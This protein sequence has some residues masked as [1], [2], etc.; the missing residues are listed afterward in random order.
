MNEAIEQHVEQFVQ[1][2]LSIA[3]RARG[4]S[5]E[6]ALQ[7]VT[8]MLSGMAPPK[9]R[10]P[11]VAAAPAP[12]PRARRQP[13]PLKATREVVATPAKTTTTAKT[14][15]GPR[16]ASRVAPSAAPVA[17]V[18]EATTSSAA[19]ASEATGPVSTQSGA[20]GPAPEREVRVLD[21]VT[22]LGRA[23]AAEIAERCGQPNGSV[24]VALRG[25]VARGLLAKTETARGFEYGLAS[26]RG[27][28]RRG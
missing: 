19:E 5:R 27:V 15:R 4:A 16:A 6:A 11:A 18:P 10:E 13:P 22:A 2:L 9:P 17:P 20:A 12:A 7:T 8:R 21:A 14:A 28:A 24:A 25:L 23:T 26:T 3:Q 1:D